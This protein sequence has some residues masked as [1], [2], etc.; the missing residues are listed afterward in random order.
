MTQ[1]LV[2]QRRKKN[3]PFSVH[4]ILKMGFVFVHEIH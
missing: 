1:T 4:M 2:E 3:G